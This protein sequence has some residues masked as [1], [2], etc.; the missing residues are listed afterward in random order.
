MIFGLQS[1]GKCIFVCVA[2]GGVQTQFAIGGPVTTY[3]HLHTMR[4]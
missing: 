4:Q 3:G 1:T 2:G